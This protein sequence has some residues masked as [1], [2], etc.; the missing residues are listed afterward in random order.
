MKTYDISNTEL[1]PCYLV[2]K[3]N[4]K[5]LINY[6]HDDYSIEEFLANIEGV[7]EGLG[8]YMSPEEV[9]DEPFY[10][11]R[12]NFS[13]LAWACIHGEREILCVWSTD[14]KDKAS[15]DRGSCSCPKENFSFFAIG[16]KCG[17]K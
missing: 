12:P 7:S 8:G 4:G 5:I 3:P 1:D 10:K 17:G 2:V 14:E 11:Q 13:S 9:L 6:Q 16:C 15:I